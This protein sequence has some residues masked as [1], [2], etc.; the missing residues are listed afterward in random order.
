MGWQEERLAQ[1]FR[2]NPRITVDYGFCR[3]YSDVYPPGHPN[4]SSARPPSQ[5]RLWE[6]WNQDFPECTR[7]YCRKIAEELVERA[8]ENGIPAPDGVFQPYNVWRL[9]DLLVKIAIDGENSTYS[10]RV[11]AD[12]FLTVAKKYY[13]L[14][15]PPLTNREATVV[16]LSEQRL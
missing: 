5:S 4:A 8:R 15:A 11:S 3:D 14:D 12:Q 10:P 2:E 13:G 9:V 16:A 6:I 7:K 1:Y